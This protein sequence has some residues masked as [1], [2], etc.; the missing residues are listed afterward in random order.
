MPT[1][2][3]DGN[4]WASGAATAAFDAFG[5]AVPADGLDDAQSLTTGVIDQPLDQNVDS[6]LDHV[7]D[8]G[9][10]DPSPQFDATV[11]EDVPPAGPDSGLDDVAAWPQPAADGDP[12]A[13]AGFDIFS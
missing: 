10:D 7:A 9:V 1:R 3:L 12:D 5:D 2:P 13:D 8:Y 11:I 6:A 4:V